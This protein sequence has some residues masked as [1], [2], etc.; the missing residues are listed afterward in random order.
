MDDVDKAQ[1]ILEG[2]CVECKEL[3]PKHTKNCSQHPWRTVLSA[4]NKLK[5]QQI[6][7]TEKDTSV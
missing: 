6:K 4:L 7:K 1:L 5:S 3:L 2:R